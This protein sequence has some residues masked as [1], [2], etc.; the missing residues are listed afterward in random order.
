M[1]R[2]YLNLFWIIS[3]KGSK[4]PKVVTCLLINDEGKLLILKR[5]EKVR[6][7]NGMWGGVAGYIEENEE[8]F[9]TALKEINEEVGLDSEDVNFIKKLEPISFT[10]FYKK[11]K[12]DWEVFVFLFKTEKKDK[13]IIDWEHSEYRWISPSEIVKYDTVPHLKEVVSKLLF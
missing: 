8:P 2:L 6:T 7:Y 11:E 3:Q 12:Y 4:M 9:D 1:V 5:S 10:D 13:V